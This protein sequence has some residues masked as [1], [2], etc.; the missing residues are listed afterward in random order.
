MAQTSVIVPV[1]NVERYLEKCV[2]SILA[3]SQG[4]LELLLIDDG[5]TDGSGALCDTLAGT[6]RRIHV[7]HQE[8]QGL[9][10]AR[11]TGIEAATG[12]WLM[13][14]DSDDWL[15]PDVLERCLELAR[16]EDAEL[17]AF[18]LRNVD[19]QG[20][21]ISLQVPLEG[22]P[23]GWSASVQEDKRLLLICPC[24]CAKLYRAEVFRRTG[25]R[26]PPRVWYEDVRTILK[27]LPGMGRVVLSN[28]AGYDYLQ[29]SSSIMNSRDDRNAEIMDALDD[30]LDWYREQGLFETYRDEL[31]FLTVSHILLNASVRLLRADPAHPLLARFDAYTNERFPDHRRCPYRS[32]LSWK[33][34]LVL[35]L[36]EGRHYA[37]AA[38]L[39]RL[40]GRRG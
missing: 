18:A 22:A 32:R 20:N 30:V 5:S 38:M 1:Y 8:N 24:A 26:F 23:E 13:F 21:S 31:C 12:D 3:Q 29:R 6:D 25:A 4:D 2:A 33:H 36:V 37:L 15:E 39:F 19:E 34:R 7:I 35:R 17:V 28:Y 16:R 10:G 11:N 40:G 27:L 14:V 9:G